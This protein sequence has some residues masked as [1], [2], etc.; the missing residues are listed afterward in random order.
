MLLR[1]SLSWRARANLYLT[2]AL[3]LSVF[4]A[5]LDRGGRGEGTGPKTRILGNFPAGDPGGVR[6]VHSGPGVNA[7]GAGAGESVGQL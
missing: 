3:R 5:H 4:F 2:I 6:A 1:L 7:C